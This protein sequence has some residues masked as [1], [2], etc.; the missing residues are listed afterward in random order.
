M[1]ARVRGSLRRAHRAG[2]LAVGRSLGGDGWGGCDEDRRDDHE[3][4]AAVA[5]RGRAIQVQVVKAAPQ[6]HLA[7]GDREKTR[8]LWAFKVPQ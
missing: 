1:L 5:Q 4:G 2:I 8:Y 3:C 7:T 6:D